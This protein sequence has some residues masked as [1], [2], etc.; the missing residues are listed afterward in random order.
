MDKQIEKLLNDQLALEYESSYVYLSMA[1]YFEHL[2]Y[3]GFAHWMKCQSKE[4]MAHF[5]K[6]FDFIFERNGMVHLGQVKAPNIHYKDVLNVFET[7]LKQEQKVTASIHNIYE[8]ALHL[9]AYASLTF[10]NWFIEEQVEEEAEVTQIVREI[11]RVKSNE[12]AMLM[13]DRELG[14]RKI[15]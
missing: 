12:S 4:E 8:K 3:Q 11:E 13:L 5:H 14:K 15:D 7:S 10:L 9:K 6:I 2:D 1:A